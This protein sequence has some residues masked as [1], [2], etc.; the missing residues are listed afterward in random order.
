MLIQCLLF[1]YSRWNGDL[2]W[3]VF[4]GQLVRN[5]CI[6]ATY[7]VVSI[8]TF[9]LQINEGK[10]GKMIRVARILNKLCTTCI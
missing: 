9:S 2:Y 7:M 3:V 10:T 8:H 4:I 5:I 6:C 1:S